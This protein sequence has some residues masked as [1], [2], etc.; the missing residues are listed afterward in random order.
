MT[1]PG[2]LHLFYHTHGDQDGEF[3]ESEQVWAEVD[4][5]YILLYAYSICFA[6]GSELPFAFSF[7]GLRYKRQGVSIDHV[8]VFILCQAIS[9]IFQDLPIF[10]KICQ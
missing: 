6:G 2:N 1:I 8:K 4:F 5:Y 10:A 3:G 7:P 9:K